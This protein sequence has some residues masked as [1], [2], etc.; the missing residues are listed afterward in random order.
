MLK[1]SRIWLQESKVRKNLVFTTNTLIL[2]IL[3]ASAQKEVS[4]DLP[5]KPS[6]T[7]LKTHPCSSPLKER[8]SAQP[9]RELLGSSPNFPS[10]NLPMVTTGF[11]SEGSLPPLLHS[12]T[13]RIPANNC[14]YQKKKSQQALRLR[15]VNICT[16]NSAPRETLVQPGKRHLTCLPRK[17]TPMPLQTNTYKNLPFTLTDQLFTKIKKWNFWD[18]NFWEMHWYWGRCKFF[19]DYSETLSG[20]QRDGISLPVLV[21]EAGK[22]NGSV[23]P[24]CNFTTFSLCQKAQFPFSSTIPFSYH[25]PFSTTPSVQ[26]IPDVHFIAPLQC[27]WL[28]AWSKVSTYQTLA[29]IRA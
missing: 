13:R 26:K 16:V 19:L 5:C 7:P 24:V 10:W 28:L 4:S 6:L 14:S 3:W 20:L 27:S 22:Q 2:P 1:E 21:A 11:A 12:S 17:T 23:Q 18:W 29:S 15:D 9:L 8:Y 25:S